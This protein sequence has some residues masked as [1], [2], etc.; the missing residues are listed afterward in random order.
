MTGEVFAFY[1][2]F[3]G[4]DDVLVV[5]NVKSSPYFRPCYIEC[6]RKY[7]SFCSDRHKICVA[8]PAGK[9][10]KVNVASNSRACGFTEI[11]AEVQT[12]RTVDLPKCNFCLLRR[13][14]EFVRSLYREACQRVQV[15]I[16]RN[17]QMARGV[18]ISIQAHKTVHAA[19][20]DVGGLFSSIPGHSVGNCV[21]DR[22]HHVA[23]DAVFVFCS[24]RWPCNESR[25]YAA[26]G[27]RV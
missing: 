21:V 5:L 6:F 11:E 12:I 14:N 17:Q 1:K 8:T 9:S 13:Q 18:R 16:W 2:A 27:L 25:R 20:D 23:E 22:S 15:E 7:T 24:R 19:M 3:D 10:V 4:C 26:A